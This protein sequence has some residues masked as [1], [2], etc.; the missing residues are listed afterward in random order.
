M[1]LTFFL[2]RSKIMAN[3]EFWIKA[4]TGEDDVAETLR[5]HIGP[6]SVG[7]WGFDNMY[8]FEQQQY[9]WKVRANHE[10]MIYNLDA[11]IHRSHDEDYEEFTWLEFVFETNWIYE[12]AETI[13]T[14]EWSEDEETDD[15]DDM[16]ELEDM[17]GWPVDYYLIIPQPPSYAELEDMNDWYWML[18]A[19]NPPQ[20]DV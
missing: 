11:L 8:A 16:P 9:E 5:K 10:Y 1:I 7:E 6:L 4:L 13:A 12:T 19:C 14:G 2:R 20:I 15:D 18:G 3:V 17:G